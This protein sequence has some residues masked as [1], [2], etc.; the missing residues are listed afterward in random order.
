MKQKKQARFLA[1]TLVV[2]LVSLSFIFI[3]A[4]PE[5][6]GVTYVSNTSKNATNPASIC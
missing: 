2:V 4:E 5:G 6:A 3:T 1:L